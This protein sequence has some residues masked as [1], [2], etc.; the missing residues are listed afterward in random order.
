MQIVNIKSSIIMSNSEN[1]KKKKA[2]AIWLLIG[3]IMIIIQIALGGITRLT[4][5][6]LSMT[7]WKPIMG[8]IPPIN[9]E[10]WVEAFKGY[11]EIAQYKYV[12]NH[13]T[14]QYFKFIFFWEW[15]HRF[16]ARFLAVVF[17]IPFIYIIKRKYFLKEMI[18]PLII[19]FVLGAL[20]GFIGWFM[21]QSGLNSSGLLHVIHIRLSIH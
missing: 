1:S 7:E 9:H 6:G 8:F 11:Q 15:F 19:L 16:W 21:V 12:N 4:G 20:Q 10:Q 18:K 13:F 5:S 14:I 17:I 2:V 3:V